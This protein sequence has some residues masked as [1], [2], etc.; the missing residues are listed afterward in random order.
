MAEA[1][2]EAAAC[3]S[4]DGTRT[5]TCSGTGADSATPAAPAPSTAVALAASVSDASEPTHAPRSPNSKKER[6][7]A[8]GAVARVRRRRKQWARRNED[9][10]D[11]VSLRWGECELL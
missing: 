2:A 4:G 11:D 6:P 1:A 10:S 8:G 5:G 9:A 7:I 3:G